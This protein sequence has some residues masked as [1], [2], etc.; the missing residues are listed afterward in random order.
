MGGCKAQASQPL[1]QVL[2]GCL[3]VG[4]NRMW[5]SSV[6]DLRVWF[7]CGLSVQSTQGFPRGAKIAGL[8]EQRQATVAGPND[9][10]H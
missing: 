7:P 3:R 4:S 5:C 1:V 10:K 6:S 9:L 2:G 8:P